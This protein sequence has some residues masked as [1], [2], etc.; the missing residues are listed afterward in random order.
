MRGYTHA[1]S[2]AAVWLAGTSQSA[3]AVGVATAPPSILFTG[4][5]LCAGA[6][7]APDIDHHNGTIAWSLPPVKVFGIT[8][9]PS[10]TAALCKVVGRVSGGHR[11]ATHSLLGVAFFAIAVFLADLVRVTWHG[12][13]IPV[14]SWVIAGFLMA[15]TLKVFGISRSLAGSRR[16]Q[17]SNPLSWVLGTAFGPWVLAFG[18]ASAITW[19]GGDTSWNWMWIA[20]AVGSFVHVVGD[21]LT[22]ERVPWLWPWN[23]S[24]PAALRRNWFVT[25]TWGTNGYFGLPVLGTVSSERKT[26][27]REGLLGVVLGAYVIYISLFEIVR[28]AGG[29]SMLI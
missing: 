24:P 19:F 15:F 3:I 26:L 10:P 11:H 9:I 22:P 18:L 5:G 12:H 17:R 1:L 20:V 27:S 4:T 21:S 29:A 28:I 25:K 6:A 13:D 2:G 14:L 23:P 16:D 7:L 8:I